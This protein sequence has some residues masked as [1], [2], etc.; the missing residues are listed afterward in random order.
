[1]YE[2]LFDEKSR[3]V[4][5]KGKEKTHKDRIIQTSHY[6]SDLLCRECDGVILFQLENNFKQNLLIPVK[7]HSKTLS[8]PLGIEQFEVQVEYQK[9]KLFFLSLLW[10]F[11]ISND[12]T[13]RAIDL[14]PHQEEIRRMIFEGD[15]REY[16]VYPFVLFSFLNKENFDA[17]I[18]VTKLSGTP[19][20]NKRDQG[21]EYL[22]LFSG[23]M[24]I[25]RVSNKR[26]KKNFEITYRGENKVLVFYFPEKKLKD[27][28]NHWFRGKLF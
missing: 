11:S 22:T 14:G 3:M 13:Y 12:P 5:F 23:L 2:D 4:E 10:R 8:P 20:L 15:P 18:S 9:I 24:M 28:V 17:P 6:E 1:M 16:Y 7:E 19:L 27:L 21:H 25:L 26:D